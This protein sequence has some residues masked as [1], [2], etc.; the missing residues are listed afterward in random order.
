MT[1]E[2]R[3]REAL[4]EHGDL[5]LRYEDQIIAAML[6]F[7]DAEIERAAQ[8]ADGRADGYRSIPMPHLL[9]AARLGEAERIAKA[10]RDLKGQP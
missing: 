2:E 3:A 6:S 8:V 9:N 10:I 4:Y 7:A 1:R 5:M